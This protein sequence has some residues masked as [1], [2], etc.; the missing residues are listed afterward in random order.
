MAYLKEGLTSGKWKT[1]EALSINGDNPIANIE[2]STTRCWA[3]GVHV[4]KNGRG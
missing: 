1:N 2:L 4:G 3:R